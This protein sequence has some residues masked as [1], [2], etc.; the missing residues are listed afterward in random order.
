M[1]WI[2]Q[3][4]RYCLLILGLV[5]GC[6]DKEAYDTPVPTVKPDPASGDQEVAPLAF[7]EELPL[8]SDATSIEVTVKG[9][10]TE[11]KFGFAAQIVSNGCG[12]I[13][14]GNYQSIDDKLKIDDLGADGFKTVCIVGKNSSGL[15]QSTPSLYQW[16]KDT[17]DQDTTEPP[18]PAVTVDVEAEYSDKSIELE[19]VAENGATH[20]QFAFR[21]GDLQCEDI[22]T[23]YGNVSKVTANNGGFSLHY[24]NPN[25]I[26]T[27]C[28]RPTDDSGA[29]TGDV[30]RYTFRKV[31]PPPPES[32]GMLDI[33]TSN[34][35][36]KIYFAS[37][38]SS[39]REIILSNNGNS[40]LDWKI[41]AESDVDW[42]K[43]GK[44]K[45]SLS[46]VNASGSASG[47]LVSGTL[48]AQE[49]NVSIWLR[50]ADIYRTDYE[51]GITTAT[52]QVHN[53]SGGDE[54]VSIS[55]N[56]YVPVVE[57]SPSPAY[58]TISLSNYKKTG[59]I[60]LL[61][62][63]RG[64]NWAVQYQFAPLVVND[65]YKEFADIINISRHSDASHNRFIE[66]TVD[67]DK[68][69]QK[70]EGYFYTA[71]YFLISNTSTK[72]TD[73][74]CGFIIPLNTIFEGGK[75]IEAGLGTKITPRFTTNFCYI[76]SIKVEKK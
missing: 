62:S 48:A 33:T 11:Y 10:A 34:R 27:L 24:L 16:I 68:L 58:P 74:G 72:N 38:S 12:S 30:S 29:V 60:I 47:S 49:K 6:Q 67:K 44:T 7:T 69:A 21:I 53:V 66:V 45:A 28:L 8:A 61:N 5:I 39:Y 43:I 3:I 17:G 42:L 56:L 70:E 26:Y 35:A 65:S 22:P 52:L 19:V 57:I 41:S 59:K 51:E 76:F 63:A 23:G 20:Y 13:T 31:D 54:S 4:M 9:T 71:F 32:A 37:A 2:K 15:E 18:K 64:G 75:E 1:L 25:G 46:A 73:W 40:E 36:T 55:V 50:L 14:Y